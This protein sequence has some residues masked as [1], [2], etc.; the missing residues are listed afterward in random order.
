ML[1]PFFIAMFLVWALGTRRA[2]LDL[3]ILDEVLASQRRNI[4]K[5]MIAMAAS[6]V[7]FPL[8]QL[9]DSPFLYLAGFLIMMTVGIVAHV[10]VPLVSVQRIDKNFVYINGACPKFLAELPDF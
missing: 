2:V 1:A 7:L 10:Y 3:P 5:F 9:L 4:L 6:F 8:G